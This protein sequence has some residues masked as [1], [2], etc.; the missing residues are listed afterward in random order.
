L[1]PFSQPRRNFIS[2]ELRQQNIVFSRQARKYEE[3]FL[4]AGL[5]LGWQNAGSVP[6]GTLMGID[7]REVRKKSGGA[8]RFDC[9]SVLFENN[10]RTLRFSGSPVFGL[11]T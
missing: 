10:W 4:Q 2:R 7:D 6:R 5:D 9:S 11:D 1:R 3:G 8:A